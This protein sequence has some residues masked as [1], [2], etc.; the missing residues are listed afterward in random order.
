MSQDAFN[1]LLGT[2]SYLS[3]VNPITAAEQA[4]GLVVADLQQLYPERD[5]RRYGAKVDGVTDDWAP[6]TTALSVASQAVSGSQGSCIYVPQGIVA[7]GSMVLLPNR[8]RILGLN[9]RGSYFRAS[10]TWAVGNGVAAYSAGTTYASNALVTNAGVLYI[11]KQG[12]NVG[13]TPA[14]SPTFWNPISAAMFYAQNGYVSGVGQSMF[15]STLEN[16][17]IDCNNVAGLG[18]VLSSA[19]QEDCGPRA[20][21]ILNFSTYGVKYQDG[22]GGAS[23]SRIEDTEIFN[24]TTAGALGVDLSTPI[25]LVSSFMLAISGGS[26]TG[27][28]SAALLAACVSVKGN[29]VRLEQVHFEQATDGVLMDGLCYVNCED[30]TGAS[31]GSGVTNLFHMASTFAGSWA[32]KI[33]RRTGATNFLQDDRSGGY[34]TIGAAD[35]GL[36]LVNAISPSDTAKG[37]CFPSGW[38]NFDGTLTGSNAPR[39]GMNVTSVNRTA[40]GTYTITLLRPMITADPAV[41]PSCNLSNYSITVNQISKTTLQLIVRVAGTATDSNEISAIIYGG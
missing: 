25:G 1:A 3:L 17:A 10:P 7:L 2:S 23:L 33:S 21:L 11:S 9:K 39:S 13:N 8:V 18:G 19:W 22:F 4:A 27:N 30:E 20:A 15:D 36:F 6:V 40:T 14:S 32:S 35:T 5:I 28:G 16:L 38:C 41:S 24:G 12:S 34:G 37:V 29:G 26:I 31:G